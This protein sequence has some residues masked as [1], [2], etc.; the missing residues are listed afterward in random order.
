MTLPPT[1]DTAAAEFSHESQLDAPPPSPIE[2][3]I[4]NKTHDLMFRKIFDYWM[5]RRFQQMLEGVREHRDHLTI[6]L[7]PNIKKA[8]YVYW[9]TDEGF[10]H[11]YLT[12]RANRALAR[13]LKYTSNNEATM[14]GTFKYTHTLKE[15]KERFAYQRDADHSRLEAAT[16]QSLC[17]KDNGNN[18]ATSVVDPDKV[19]HEAA[20]KPYKNRMYRLGSFF[21]NNLCTSTLRHSSASTTSRP[22]DPEDGVNLK[23]QMLLLTR[24]FHPQ[25]QQLRESEERYQAILSC[26]TD[27]DDLMM[28]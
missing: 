2:K 6:W 19:W 11:R 13:S 9:E 12:N 16:Q 1:T 28:E 5:A 3:F 7:Y 23:E 27:T 25:T 17:T 22:V 26:M 10:K 14:A 8:L 20:P 15:N 21:P 18:S 24:S 4:W